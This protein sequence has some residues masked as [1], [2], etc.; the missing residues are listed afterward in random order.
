MKDRLAPV[1]SAD[2]VVD[3]HLVVGEILRSEQ[4]AGVVQS[5]DHLPGQVAFV[6]FFSSALGYAS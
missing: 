4:T 5:L 1:G 3:L 6:E 2:G